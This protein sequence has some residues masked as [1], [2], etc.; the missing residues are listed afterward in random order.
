MGATVQNVRVV[1][2]DVGNSKRAKQS[3]FTNTKDKPPPIG[4]K[5]GRKENMTVT[6]KQ[7]NV[8]G[9]SIQIDSEKFETCYH[10]RASQVFSDGT[11][12]Y[13]FTDLIY[14]TMEKAKA[15][16]NYLRRQAE[17]GNL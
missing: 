10:V 12:G 7:T 6:I 5:V 11:C 17:K 4:E 3:H 14:P 8:N 16:F 15:R 1:A 13:Y 2:L 9:V